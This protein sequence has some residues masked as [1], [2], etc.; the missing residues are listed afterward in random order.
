MIRADK[1][2]DAFTAISI[3][4]SLSF[5]I[6]AFSSAV[7]VNASNDG[8][9]PE[10]YTMSYGDTVRTY[11]MYLPSS[12][13]DGAPLVVYTHGYGS[14]TRWRDDL[15]AVADSCGFAVCYPDGLPDSRGNDS[16]KV[17]YPSQA[18]MDINEADFFRH[19]LDEVTARFNLSRENVFMAGWSNGGDLCYL[20]TYTDPALFRAYGSVGGLMYEDIYKNNTLTLPV[21]FIEIHGDA[22]EFAMWQG[23]H[24]NT[25]GWGPYIPVPFAVAAVAANNRCTTQAI[26]I[27]PTKRDANRMVKRTFYSDAP[28]DCDVVIYE[29]E[30]GK[31]SWADED[32]DTSKIL[33][34]FFSRYLVDE[35]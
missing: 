8:M 6:V 10:K 19:L 12:I 20:L 13:G 15:N 7:T 27:F 3:K 21:P 5:I 32:V 31:H 18:S 23:D 4:L 34:D 1:I 33:W 26:D 25:G 9:L 35:N 11:R 17:G 14:K 30:G 24:L 28:S 2:I 22:D 16:W 29:I